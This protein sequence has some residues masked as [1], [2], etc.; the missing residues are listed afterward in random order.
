MCTC[1]CFLRS[2][3]LAKRRSQPSNSHLKGFSPGG[4]N[5]E[6]LV[7]VGN[8][9]TLSQ[10]LFHF[11]EE[12][13]TKKFRNLFPRR[14]RPGTPFPLLRARP[15]SSLLQASSPPLLPPGPGRRGGRRRSD[16]DSILVELPSLEH[17]DPLRL[18]SSKFSPL[19]AR[20]TF[21]RRIELTEELASA[22][23][24]VAVPAKR[25]CLPPAPRPVVHPAHIQSWPTLFPKVGFVQTP[26]RWNN[27]RMRS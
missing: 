15:G 22:Q 24:K 17:P 7:R 20:S 27:F 26:R 3:L 5:T 18:F 19:G 11:G 9:V 2:L 23:F 16:K 10:F 21:A 13:H 1:E 25:L 12:D 8:I 14:S 6:T 4:G